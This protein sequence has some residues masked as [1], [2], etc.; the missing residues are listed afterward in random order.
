MWVVDV[1]SGPGRLTLP[2]AQLVGP[3]GV[4][5]A[6]DTQSEMLRILEERMAKRGVSNIRTILGG[7]GE[8]RLSHGVFDR[9]LL[10]TVLGEIPDQLRALR[11]IY[12]A[13]KPGGILSITEV[14]P[15]PHYQRKTTVRKLAEQAGFRLDRQFGGWLAFTMNFSKD[16]AA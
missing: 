10:V 16:V 14:F 4:V 7:V 9:A 15:D 1:G 13:L 6:L 2:A 12:D 8:G 5:V 11:E 3:T